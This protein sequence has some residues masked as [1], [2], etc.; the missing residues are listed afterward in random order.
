MKDDYCGR[1]T[2]ITSNYQRVQM[3][4]DATGLDMLLMIEG[5]PDITV[6]YKGCWGV[7]R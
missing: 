3:A 7:T 1:C 6:V 5:G 4:I 2:N